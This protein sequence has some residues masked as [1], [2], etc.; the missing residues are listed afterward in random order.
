MS[1]RGLFCCP[2]CRARKAA[3][4]AA[5]GGITDYGCIQA[6]EAAG[7]HRQKRYGSARPGDS[8]SSPCAC[9]AHEGSPPDGGPR[10]RSSGPASLPE[11]AVVCPGEPCRVSGHGFPQARASV[12]ALSGPEGSVPGAH[13]CLTLPPL[14]PILKSAACTAGRPSQRMYAG[15][16]PGCGSAA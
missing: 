11:T 5:P 12:P 10:E 2:A 13:G 15:V 7:H 1:A 4:P 16:F 6:R 14:P 9:P 8:R 3:V